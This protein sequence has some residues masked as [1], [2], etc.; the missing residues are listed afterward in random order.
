MFLCTLQEDEKAKFLELAY[1]AAKVDGEFN[2]KEKNLLSLYRGELGIHAYK[3]QEEDKSQLIEF[4]KTKDESTKKKV[5]FEVCGVIWIDEKVRPE[6]AELLSE[7]QKEFDI[8]ETLKYDIIKWMDT[9]L[10]PWVDLSNE[11]NISG[12][13]LLGF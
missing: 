8:E 2:E 9:K 10:K 6:E 11:L 13:K 7:L 3:I 5:F 12:A 1:F 4:F